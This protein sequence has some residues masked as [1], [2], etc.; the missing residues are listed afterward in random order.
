[1]KNGTSRKCLFFFFKQQNVLHTFWMKHFKHFKLQSDC[2]DIWLNLLKYTEFMLNQKEEKTKHLNSIIFFF[3]FLLLFIFHSKSMTQ[4]FLFNTNQISYNSPL[5]FHFLL[6]SYLLFLHFSFFNIIWL[7][8]NCML[9]M[10]CYEEKWISHCKVGFL[11]EK[12][13]FIQISFVE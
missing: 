10:W 8:N 2:F 11:L 1:M 12:M 9:F 6:L 3:V 5:K 13:K 4:F 7:A